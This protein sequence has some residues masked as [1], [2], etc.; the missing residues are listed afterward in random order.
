MVEVVKPNEKVR[1]LTE[2]PR[3]IPIRMEGSVA[4]EV[5]LSLWTTFNPYKENHSGY[6]GE[7]FHDKVREAVTAAG[8]RDDIERLGGP[9]CVMWLAVA[10]LID[11]AP[12]PHEPERVF[13]WVR[14]MA[15]TRFRRWALGYLSHSGSA[16]LIEQA[17]NGDMDALRELICDEET[18]EK[19]E[20]AEVLIDYFASASDELN[21]E[22]GET[23]LRYYE[24]V[25]LKLDIDFTSAVGRA[26]AARRAVASREDAKSVVE[27]VTQGLDYDIPLGVT[28]VVL[29]PSIVVK[30][31]S[32]I[33]QHRDALIVYYG[34]ADEFIDSDPEAPPSWLVNTYKALS[35]ERR[36]RILRRLSEGDAGLDELT[37]VLGLSKSTVHHH[38]S[39]L[40]SAGLVRVHVPAEKGHV[41]RTYGLRDAALGDATGF[42]NSY[43]RAPEL[44]VEHA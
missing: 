25:F 5:L 29:V 36:L 44:E 19:C 11:T 21:E 40:R 10:G 37:E 6:L 42:L 14:D 38:M 17:A 7:E 13:G 20:K 8:L 28:R 23:I 24:E 31:L 1:D 30:P 4:F 18:E 2:A 39:I 32:V 9:W 43:L 22:L 15:P 26:A 12:H 35:D 3:Q 41:Q 34:M 16:P 33:D 27:E